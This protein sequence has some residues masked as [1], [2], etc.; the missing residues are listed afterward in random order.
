MLSLSLSLSLSLVCV[1][2][3]VLSNDR[4]CGTPTAV[5]AGAEA[6]LRAEG[7]EGPEWITTAEWN[8]EKRK[9][10]HDYWHGNI[11]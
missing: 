1:C 3:N 9:E 2:V 6:L 5:T 7:T 11:V 8:G 4:S 10:F